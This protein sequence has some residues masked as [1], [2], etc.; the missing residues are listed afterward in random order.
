MVAHQFHSL[1][2]HTDSSKS[3]VVAKSVCCCFGLCVNWKNCSKE[4][5]Q[6]KRARAWF[7]S[8]YSFSLI[9]S[10]SLSVFSYRSGER[11]SFLWMQTGWELVKLGTLRSFIVSNP[12]WSVH[13]V[14]LLFWFRFFAFVF[15]SIDVSK[16]AKHSSFFSEHWNFGFFRLKR[17][18][19]HFD[20]NS[21]KYWF[22]SRCC[23]AK[24]K[25]SCKQREVP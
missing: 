5:T 25:H 13:S 21:N 12:M 11:T 20:Q 22:F 9:L 14:L 1:V 24:Q 16:A 7:T 19:W 15:V 8:I 10:F 2:A 18:F 17:L 6:I 3:F 4:T 23:L